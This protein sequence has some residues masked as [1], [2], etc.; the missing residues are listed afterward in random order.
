VHVERIGFTPLKGGRHEPHPSVRLTGDGPVGDRVLCLVDPARGRVL[1]TVENP[2]LVQAAARLD[3]GHLAVTMPSGA[4]EGEPQPTGRRVK[5]DYWGRAAEVE[6]L[7]GPWS[8]AYSAHLGYDVRLARPTVPSD[9]VYG[10]PVTIVSTAS[11]RELSTRIGAPVDPARFR[12][13]L[14]V[15]TGDAEPYAEEDW[16]GRE[17]RVGAATLR[18][19][20]PVPRCAVVDLDPVTGTRDID[21]LGTL[22]GYRRREGEVTFGV[23]AVVTGHGT[24]RS[25]DH[26][27]VER[28]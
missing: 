14:V 16:C 7:D 9:I 27:V 18:I 11:V 15:D 6:E 5:L 25:G 3:D 12:A 21:V 23:D 17:V 13:T 20:A 24:V 8:A 10:A 28:G 4:V 22:A 19:G 26:V 2:S 1:R